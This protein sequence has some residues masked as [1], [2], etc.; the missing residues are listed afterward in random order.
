MPLTK[1]ESLATRALSPLDCA[2]LGV[3]RTLSPWILPV[4]R[5]REIRVAL[6]G[7]ITVVVALTGTLLVPFWLLALGPILWGTPHI[8]SDIRYLVIRPGLHLRREIWMPTAALILASGAGIYPMQTGLAACAAVALL[9]NGTVGRRIIALTIIGGLA[10]AAT[11]AGPVSMIVFAHAHNF[12]AV[13]L[14]WFWRPRLRAIYALVPALFLLACLLLIGGV[15]APLTQGF[16]W[17][18]SGMDSD[19][20]LESLAPNVAAPWGIRLV[21]LFAFAQTVH[22]GI[23]LRLIP[24]DDRPQDTPRTFAA[25]ARALHR[26]LGT[27]LMLGAGILIL[28][29]AVWAVFDLA[30]ARYHYLRMA[31]FHGYLE[32]AAATYLFVEGYQKGRKSS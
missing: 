14:W 22:Y 20:H 2:R 19:Y 32:L 8:L 10:W 25:S 29:I 27:W 17:I 12:I 23:W 16:D 31:L 18:P 3:F 13:M 15:L 28:G 5:S 4:I 21:L 6:F 11:S 26:D 9:C 7:S 1:F 30:G 24:E